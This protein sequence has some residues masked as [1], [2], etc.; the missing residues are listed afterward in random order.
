[1]FH[2]G[3]CVLFRILRLIYDIVF[4]LGYCVSFRILCFIYDIVFH[5]EYCVLFRILRLIRILCL[6]SD[7]PLQ[8][9]RKV[10]SMQQMA[11]TVSSII[12]LSSHHFERIP[13]KLFVKNINQIL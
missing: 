10:D 1:M 13:S 2:L 7:G 9:N 4:H 3:Y 12:G 11:V 5:L 6:I 8:Y